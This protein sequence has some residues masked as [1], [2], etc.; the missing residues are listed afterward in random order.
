M[1]GPNRH[2]PP[3]ILGPN[4]WSVGR[5]SVNNNDNTN[6]DIHPNLIHHIRVDWLKGLVWRFHQ[7]Q[8]D[9]CD[10]SNTLSPYT[11]LMISI[12]HIS[13]QLSSHMHSFPRHKH[14]THCR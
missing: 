8:V 7:Q 10:T 1:I 13:Y 3:F 4:H 5:V 6:E 2:N 14:T 11:I 12:H 9:P